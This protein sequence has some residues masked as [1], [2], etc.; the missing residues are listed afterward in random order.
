MNFIKTILI[1]FI[2]TISSKI[3]SQNWGPATPF[4]GAGLNI[5]GQGAP[6]ISKIYNFNNEMIVSGLFN[7]IGGIVAHSIASWNGASWNSVGPGNFLTTSTAVNDMIEYNGNLYITADK[8]YK[9]DGNS[10]SN[11]FFLYNNQ[12]Q[13]VRGTDLHVFNNE[14]YINNSNANTG[15]GLI[16]FDG[17]S[18]LHLNDGTNDEGSIHCIEDFNGELYVG[19]SQG[20]FKYQ[21]NSNF[22]N[23][24]GIVSATPE[25]LDLENYNGDLYAIGYLSS[26]G[27]ITVNN[28]A[29]YNG[30][31]WQNILLPGTFHPEFHLGASPDLSTYSNHFSKIGNDLFLSTL[32][33]PTPPYPN[34]DI[35]PVVKFDG[36]QWHDL[37]LNFPANGWGFCVNEYNNEL[38]CGGFFESFSSPFN[39]YTNC[40]AKLYN[41]SEL[42]ENIPINFTSKPNPTSSEITISSEKFSN[43][44]YT[45]C[46][47]MGRIVGSGKLTGT[48]T[49]ISLS[50]LSKGIYLLKVEGDYEAAMVVKE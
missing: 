48:T 37:S 19:T 11:F 50:S 10:F 41:S 40:I 29:K 13:P 47:Q 20:L 46:D 5:V 9:W 42:E 30:Q 3:F 36:T 31:F 7:S 25:I 17:N 44:A 18:F 49:N 34:F 21:Q 15:G 27:G 22:I 12:N 43:E 8:L 16:K 39:T 28:F 32:F 26:I 4:P 2:L 14:L 33:W 45:L 1:I 6:Y 23:C 24:N 38:F 35:N